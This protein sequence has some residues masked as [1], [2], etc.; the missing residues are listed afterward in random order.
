MAL[1]RIEDWDDILD[2]PK[3]KHS[4]SPSRI[5]KKDRREM[6]K[7]ANVLKEIRNNTSEH[8][9]I[10][11]DQVCQLAEML[12]KLADHYDFE[13]PKCDHGHR[14]WWTD[15]ELIEDLPNNKK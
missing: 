14:D 5:S 6:L 8:C 11:Y 7:Y 2:P 4:H 12:W 10:T 13:Q 9:P 15:Y 1:N 3:K